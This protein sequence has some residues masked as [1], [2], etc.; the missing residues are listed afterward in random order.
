MEVK[1]YY[2]LREVQMEFPI[3]EFFDAVLTGTVLVYAHDQRLLDIHSLLNSD[4]LV[5]AIEEAIRKM[6]QHWPSLKGTFKELSPLTELSSDQIRRLLQKLHTM[7]QRDIPYQD[8]VEKLITYSPTRFDNDMAENVSPVSVN[9]L[10]ISILA[11][12]SGNFYDGAAGLGGTLVTADRYAKKKKGDLEIYGQE[13]NPYNWAV[14]RLRL[15]LHGISGE[16]LAKG[17]SL[18]NPG[19]IED[20]CLKKFDY[21]FLDGPFGMR[22]KDYDVV[23]QDPYQ[24]FA[25]GTPN[26]RSGDMALMMHVF[27]SLNSSGK[28]IITVTDGAL[29]RGGAEAEIRKRILAEDLIEAVIALPSKLYEKTSLPVNLILFNQAKSFERKNKILFINAS[30]LY[31]ELTKSRRYLLSSHIKEIT[32]AVRSGGEEKGTSVSISLTDIKEANLLPSRY[33]TPDTLEIQDY[34]EVKINTDRLEKLQTVPL[35]ETAVFFPGFN[36][37][38][39]HKES[40]DGACRIVKLSDVQDGKVA[41]D[42]VSRYH[43]PENARLEKYRL[44]KGD[45]I[46]AI[47]GNSLKT[48]VIPEHEGILLLSQNFI[49][50][51]CRAELDPD[52]LKIYLDSPPGQYLLRS[53]LS[54]T[55]V[56]TI[57]KR[58]VQEL[59]IPKKSLH[60]QALL[61]RHFHETEAA[62]EAQITKLKER[63]KDTRL[64]LYEEMGIRNVF[65]LTQ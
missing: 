64:A 21:A 6:E 28:G 42:S 48:A 37:L 36:I 23:K 50:I 20:G 57:S 63:Q 46:L 52:Y 45:V 8:W 9:E 13:L 59:P 7:K 19:H 22:I 47:R 24:Q 31:S 12:V 16:C 15:L 38:S 25:Y 44:Q 11:P 10:A 61:V 40:H 33:L 60:D 29:F 5:S 65:E 2:M 35:K 18:A 62:I 43:I 53:K 32:D 30:N 55:T 3:P 27:S 54:G 26:R 41:V 51:R 14:A 58:D 49:G 34:G 39:K 17:D 4:D 1:L 56:L